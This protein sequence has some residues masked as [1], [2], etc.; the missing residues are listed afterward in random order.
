MSKGDAIAI[1]LWREKPCNG[2][3]A[4]CTIQARRGRCAVGM[5]CRMAGP[6]RPRWKFQACCLKSQCLPAS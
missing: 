2:R 3:T 6:G 1:F 5:K 4:F